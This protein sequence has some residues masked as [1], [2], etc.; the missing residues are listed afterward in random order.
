MKGGRLRGVSPVVVCLKMFKY[1][2]GVIMLSI[3]NNLRM[4]RWTFTGRKV[5]VYGA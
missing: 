3:Y 2:L 5:D 4:V 1:C